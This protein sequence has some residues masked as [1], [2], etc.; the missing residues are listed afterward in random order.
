MHNAIYRFR[1]AVPFY[2]NLILGKG[3]IR[4]YAA[5]LADRFIYKV[6]VEKDKLY[7]RNIRYER[8]RILS[9]LVGTVERALTNKNISTG[10]RKKIIDVFVGNVFLASKK[11]TKEEFIKEFK[12]EPPGFVTIS[13]GKKCNL[14]CRG[15]YAGS[16]SIASAKLD[17]Q[18]VDRIISEKTS[19]WNSFFTVISGGEPLMWYS[20]GKGILDLCRDHPDNYFL[21]YTNGTLINMNM[22]NRMA[23]AGNISPAISVEGFKAETD[24]RRGEGVYEKVLDAMANLREAGVPFG[25]SVT[26]TRDN[27]DKI[28]SDEFVDFYFGKHGAVYG[29]IFQYMPIGRYQSLDLMITPEQRVRLLKQE[30]HILHD[31]KIF[32]PDFWN[33]GVYSEGCL[34]GGRSGGTIYIEWNGKVTHCVFYPYSKINKKDIFEKG[35]NLNG[36]L[37]SD[38][39]NGIRSW[40]YDYGFKING[41]AVKNL[42]MPCGI[43][44]H[45]EFTRR[46]LEAAKPVPIDEEAAEAVNDLLYYRGLVENNNIL[47]SLTEKIWNDEFKG[48]RKVKQ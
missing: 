28:I 46:H 21:M 34:A 30:K 14:K 16:D 26:A 5:Y 17:Y 43:R 32:F 8:Y 11:V 22:A 15:C 38:L 4:K 20:N 31:K 19:L 12:Q 7:T 40:Q 13:P 37:R 33:G 2:L 6:I 10:V 47:Y 27:A 39:I 42:I 23:E 29:W 24:E 48:N 45:Y 44:D 25:V 36:T 41:D 1:K 18:T 9:N 35:G 3:I